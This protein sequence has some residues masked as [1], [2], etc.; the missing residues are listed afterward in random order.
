M[1][2]TNAKTEEELHQKILDDMMNYNEKAAGH[3]DDY[4]GIFK[5]FLDDYKTNLEKLQELKELEREYMTPDYYINKNDNNFS[6]IYEE[7]IGNTSKVTNKK[8]LDLN[9]DYSAEMEKAIAA[10]DLTQAK[11]LQ[12]LRDEKADILDITLGQGDYRS[13]NKVIEDAMK[14]FGMSSNGVVK[15]ASTTTLDNSV[16]YALEIQ[17]AIARGDYDDAARYADLRTQKAEEKKITLGTGAYKSNDDIIKEA[18]NYYGVR[19]T[20]D[21][22]DS[23]GYLA[24]NGNATKLLN[25]A[26]STNAKTETIKQNVELVAKAA[27]QAGYKIDSVGSVIASQIAA[28]SEKELTQEQA[29]ALVQQMLSTGISKDTTSLVDSSQGI[30]NDTASLVESS[31]EMNKL[32]SAMDGSIDKA[33]EYLEKMDASQK[34]ALKKEVINYT[35]SSSGGSSSSKKTTSSSSGSN[36]NNRD[37]SLEIKDAVAKGD[38]AKAES[39]NKERNEKIDAANKS[40]SGSSGAGQDKYSSVSQLMSAK[41]WAGGIENGPV[42]YTG[43]AML[44]GTPSAPEYVLNNDQAYNLLYNMSSSKMAEFESNAK[45]DGGVQYIVQGDIIL[46]G[47]DDPSK[48][49]QEVTIAMGNRWNVTKNK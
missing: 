7:A 37:I 20:E 8:T 14:K 10:G 44:H 5:D 39:L 9:I 1:E 30:S 41:G 34:E 28:S 43:L 4:I 48:F 16:D 45:S 13:N 11:Y 18:L 49:W 2:L 24:S 21:K 19:Y 17:K 27:D 3:Y 33:I 22:E 40:G 47:I 15:N 42:T 35:S 25:E 26:T 6:D 31:Q 46:E 38:M 32:M 29:N 12:T 36:W 23:T